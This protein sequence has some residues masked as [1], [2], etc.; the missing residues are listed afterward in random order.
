MGSCKFWCY[1]PVVAL[2]APEHRRRSWLGILHTLAGFFF[3]PVFGHTLCLRAESPFHQEAT[4]PD[5]R[6]S[7]RNFA[8][9]NILFKLNA[10]FLYIGIQNRLFFKH[11]GISDD[12]LVFTPYSVD[13]SRFQNDAAKFIAQKDTVR[14]EFGLPTDSFVVLF[15]G[16]FIAKK[17][18]L[19][20]LQAILQI[21]NPKIVAVF[22]GEGPLREDMEKFIREHKLEQRIFF[23]GFVNQSVIPRYYA[24]ADVFVMCSEIGETW[25][26]S[27]NEAM[28]FSLPVVLSDQIGCADDLV[29]E[30][31]NGFKYPC[32]NILALAEKIESLATMPEIERRDMGAAS[33]K[34]IGDYSF[35]AIIAGLQKI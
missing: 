14:E 35:A 9:K 20:L 1:Q 5:W 15:S 6:K 4:N 21:K 31:K 27:T 13:N 30:G 18:P 7:L 3:A 10:R 12:K 8:L 17:R 34:K 22:V 28:N 26:L 33:L 25:G 16:K 23:T 19:D 24:C 32:G 11:F 29:E 2:A